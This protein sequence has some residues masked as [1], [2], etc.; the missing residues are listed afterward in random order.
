MRST[1][2]KSLSIVIPAKNEAAALDEL[3]PK[4]KASQPDADILVINDGST[5]D[6]ADVCK[7][8]GVDVHSN[9]YS[10]GNGG[11]IKAGARRARGEVIVF[12]DADGQHQ[13][14]DIQPL[15]DKL[16]EGFDMV[17]G[18]R[19]ASQHASIFRRAANQ[20]YNWL[21]S[22]IVGH[23]IRDLTSGMRAVRADRFRQFLHL[24]PNGFSYPTTI[25]M[26]FFRYGYNVG[27]QP[28]SVLSRVGK[29]HINLL[30]DGFRFLI[31]IFKI[32]TL[33]SPLKM[34]TPLALSIFTIGV[35]YYAYTYITADQFTNMSALLLTLSF[36]VFLIGLVSEQITSLMYALNEQH[37]DP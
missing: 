16:H 22:T 4:L 8:H 13:P 12:M 17:V 18:Q 27:Y 32:G 15:L 34:F 26:A 33:Y 3:L 35:S 37:R 5:D 23:S 2:E 20:F 11:A 25:T 24:L 21:A 29:S 36:L 1:E 9:R 14:S 7:K 30:K 31:I 28:I 10:L 19:S 6:T